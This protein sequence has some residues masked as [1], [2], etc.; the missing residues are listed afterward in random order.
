M[1]NFSD[2]IGPCGLLDS[3][4]IDQNSQ[5]SWQIAYPSVIVN[6]EVM[7]MDSQM[8]ASGFLTSFTD[9]AM[10]VLP[11]GTNRV[12]YTIADEVSP[13]QCSFAVE[14]RDTIAPTIECNPTFSVTTNPSGLTFT[15]TNATTDSIFTKLED[16]C[17][18][19][20]I[21]ISP[22]QVSC[23]S[24]GFESSDGDGNRYSWQ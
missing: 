24:A 6:Y 2:F 7:G 12:T 8:V 5:I 11:V 23:D 9:V 1:I 18:I 20:T 16:N 10:E 19:G 13:T 21:S 15:E 22:D 3:L 17:S 14:V 4:N